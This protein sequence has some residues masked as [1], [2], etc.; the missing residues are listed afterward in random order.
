MELIDDQVAVQGGGNNS[1][2]PS[3]DG[4]PAKKRRISAAKRW[5]FTINNPTEEI[6]NLI[7]T[8]GA[9]VR[10]IFYAR[11]HADDDDKT[12]HFQGYLEFKSRARPLPQFKEWK[13][14]WSKARG[15]LKDNIKYTTKEVEW[16]WSRGVDKP[17]SMTLDM[18]PWQKELY[19]MLEGEPHP[20]NIYWLWDRNGGSG[21]TEFARYYCFKHPSEAIVLSGKASDMKNGIVQYRERNGRLPKVV[22]CDFPRSRKAEHIS[23]TGL[24]MIKNMFFYSGKYEGG[25]VIGHKPHMLCFAN[26]EPAYDQLSL[27]RWQVAEVPTLEFAKSDEGKAHPMNGLIIKNNPGA[28]LGSSLASFN[29]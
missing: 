25:M 5:C 4:P 7:Q 11:E 8:V 15:S 29:M 26:C 9:S 27:D 16:E 6:K 10:V 1:P 19:E 20:R 24:E 23:W 21:K 17:F 28:G 14:H 12:T 2:P 3:E 18:V 13:A 22:I